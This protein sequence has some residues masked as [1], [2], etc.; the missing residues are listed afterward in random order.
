MYA[1]YWGLAEIPFRNTLDPRW[2]Y[3]S[4][5]HEEG[6]ARLLFVIENRRRCGVLSGPAGIGKSL[7]LELLRS[8]A[9]RGAGEIVRVDLFGRTSR[10]M[11]WE[12]AAELGLCPHNDEGAHR[13]WRKLHDHILAN[14]YAQAPLVLVLDHLDRAHAECAGVVERLQHLSAGGDTGLTLILGVRGD[15]RGPLTDVARELSDLRIELGPLDRD[16]T[17]HYV[18][19]LLFK[20]GASRSLFESAAFDRLFA[21]TR[22]IPRALNRLCDLALLAG[23][24]A[25]APKAPRY[26]ERVAAGV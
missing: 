9:G 26:R 1:N 7:L 24:A 5:S 22:G 10:E 8:E 12:T 4:P 15:L 6:L 11:L 17:E 3:E 14:R 16:Q 13:L 19:T 23:M 20:A 2:F 25:A 21:E 18:E